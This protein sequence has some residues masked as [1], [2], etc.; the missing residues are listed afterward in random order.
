M[1]KI[2]TILFIALF[3]II[4]FICGANESQYKFIYL[5][6][7][8]TTTIQS[9]MKQ[10][11]IV[12]CISSLIILSMDIF[13]APNLVVNTYFENDLILAG[14]FILTAWPLGFYVKIEGQHIED[15]RRISEY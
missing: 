11:L 14:I 10:G 7:I 1:N 5:F 12:S 15:V 3:S 9:G 13:M 6:I 2:E 8:I 4:I